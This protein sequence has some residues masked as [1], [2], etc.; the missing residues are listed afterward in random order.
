MD[1][2]VITPSSMAMTGLIVRE[3]LIALS[4]K[5][6]Q[7]V[8]NSL[9]SRPRRQKKYNRPLLEKLMFKY[10]AT[11]IRRVHDDNATK[12]LTMVVK[13]MTMKKI[14]IHHLVDATVKFRFRNFLFNRQYQ[15]RI[16]REVLEKMS[17]VKEN[18]KP[19]DFDRFQTD[20]E[21][22]APRIGARVSPTP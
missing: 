19:E 15:A 18:R 10:F 13:K 20:Y 7:V 8:L 9:R 14:Q 22:F 21:N 16:A 5:E 11:V 17:V 3:V 4:M 1:S 2:V 6:M 12:I